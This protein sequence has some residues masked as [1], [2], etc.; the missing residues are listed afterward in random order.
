M[1]VWIPLF[2]PRSLAV[3]VHWALHNTLSGLSEKAPRSRNFSS[4]L[5]QNCRSPWIQNMCSFSSVALFSVFTRN[6]PAHAASPGETALLSSQVP[7]C[8]AM[9]SLSSS[10]LLSQFATQPQLLKLVSDSH[11][12]DCPPGCGRSSQSP[13]DR[14]AESFVDRHLKSFEEEEEQRRGRRN[15]KEIYMFA[16]SNGKVRYLITLGFI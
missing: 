16:S 3:A 5:S 10:A 6:V 14:E 7:L 15:I 9:I 12:C 8:Q 11:H 4:S 1:L 13:N 2:F